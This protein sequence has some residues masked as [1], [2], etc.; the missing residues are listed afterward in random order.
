MACPRSLE[1]KIL[2]LPEG[3]KF[4][5]HNEDRRIASTD[6]RSQPRA[7]PHLTLVT[8][9]TE[10]REHLSRLHHNGNCRA[11]ERRRGHP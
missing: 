4:R 10:G 6:R 7:N 2:H 5:G 11:F 1:A 9:L 3:E 8:P